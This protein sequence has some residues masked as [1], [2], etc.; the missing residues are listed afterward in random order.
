MHKYVEGNARS[1]N[2]VSLF[3]ILEAIVLRHHTDAYT[4]THTH[5]QYAKHFAK[6]KAPC[7]A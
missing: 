5:T 6:H 1:Y 2:C 4:H 3:L 7:N